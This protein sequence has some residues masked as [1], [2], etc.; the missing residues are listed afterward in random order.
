LFGHGDFLLTSR[1]ANSSSPAGFRR[2]MEKMDDARLRLVGLTSVETRFA[3][4]RG[5]APPS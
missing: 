1:A 4:E 3:S 5:E 2:L